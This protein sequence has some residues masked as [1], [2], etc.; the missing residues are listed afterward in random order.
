[1]IEFFEVIEAISDGDLNIVKRYVENGGDIEASDADVDCEGNT[2]LIWAAWA[3]VENKKICKYLLEHGANVH[4]TDNDGCTALHLAGPKIVNLLL[5]HG[6]DVNTKNDYGR[7]P[8]EE[9]A[10][11]IDQDYDYKKELRRSAEILIKHGARCDSKLVRTVF[12]KLIKKYAVKP[13]L[14]V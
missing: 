5:D 6:A 8:L 14:V 1:M 9:M 10:K 2:P 7:T 13:I 12:S 3:G 11:H 4:A